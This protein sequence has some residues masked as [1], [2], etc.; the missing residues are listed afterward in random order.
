VLG[1]TTAAPCPYKRNP[2]EPSAFYSI[3]DKS[4]VQ[5]CPM[6]QEFSEKH[7]TC[8]V[9]VG[10]G[11]VGNIPWF[12]SHNLLIFWGRKGRYFWILATF[13]VNGTICHHPTVVFS[14][15]SETCHSRHSFIP[16]SIRLLKDDLPSPSL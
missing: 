10:K 5:Y 7:C 1:T 15:F 14:C 8:L 13:W 3:Y 6:G 12:K 4:Q 16:S 9:V 11:K 2:R